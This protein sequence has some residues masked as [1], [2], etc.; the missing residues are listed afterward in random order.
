MREDYDE[1]VQL[2]QSGAISDLQFLL[3]QDE[4]ATAYQAAMAASDRELSDETAGNGCWTMKS[5]IY[6]SS[7]WIPQVTKPCNVLQN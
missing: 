6:M 4:L 7:L 3:A 5:T 2:N 1:L